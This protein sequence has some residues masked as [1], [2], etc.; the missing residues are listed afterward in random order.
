MIFLQEA[1]VLARPISF[2]FSSYSSCIYSCSLINK[3][4]LHIKWTL[5]RLQNSASAEHEIR[6]SVVLF[7]QL[8]LISLKFIPKHIGTQNY[9]VCLSLQCA[10][11][12]SR[13]TEETIL[14][15]IPFGRTSCTLWL[16]LLAGFGIGFC[17]RH[18]RFSFQCMS[19]WTIEMTLQ[20]RISWK[21]SPVIYESNGSSFATT[22]NDSNTKSRKRS[23]EV[24]LD[25]V[26]PWELDARKAR[27]GSSV[28][29]HTL[30]VFAQHQ[31]PMKLTQRSSTRNTI[32]GSQ[33]LCELP[34]V[35][36]FLRL[37]IVWIQVF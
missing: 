4:V 34:S 2:W 5:F 24:W 17:G 22:A 32:L 19:I 12:F 27:R 15:W 21:K 9:S 14:S 1:Y 6:I 28:F 26:F 18:K 25:W 37:S 33:W 30:C 36:F 23:S 13:R 3:I 35:Q 10:S 11:F 29:V 16:Q 20:R 8:Y 7:C 31:S